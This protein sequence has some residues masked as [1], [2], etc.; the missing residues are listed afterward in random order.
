MKTQLL[1]FLSIVI[2]SNALIIQDDE[3]NSILTELTTLAEKDVHHENEDPEKDIRTNILIPVDDYN[4]E[5]KSEM[6]EVTMVDKRV[7]RTEEPTDICY[8][9]D[10][11]EHCFDRARNGSACE[12]EELDK[13]VVCCNVTD[14]AKSIGCLGSTN[15]KN[16]HI[17]NA[18]EAEVNLNS[19]NSHLKQLDSLAITNG[20]I[21]RITGAFSKF[22]SIKCL[23]FASNKIVEVYD[24]ALLHANQLKFL[25]LSENNITRLPSIQNVTVNVQ[26]NSKISCINISTALDKEVKFLHKENSYCER[27]TVYWWFNDTAS[28]TIL[29]LEKMKKLNEECPLGCRC[30]P[31]TMQYVSNTLEVTAKVD[32]SSLGL[33][34]FPLKL[35][36]ETV[37]LIVSNNSISS[38]STL[39]SSEYYQ[40]V[41][42]LFIDDNEISSMEELAGTKFFENFTILSLKNNKI[43]EIPNYILSSLEKNL[44]SG[45]VSFNLSF[46]IFN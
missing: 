12:C 26:G 25:N 10:I 3:Q 15:L 18:M 1:V 9:V 17:I 16:L 21:T 36:S 30:I 35:P 23:N 28:V 32:C 29:A 31:S 45:K 39:V 24:R 11:R 13:G 4:E 33:F 43:K 46:F 2:F 37:E 40:N 14:I 27:E 6:M 41:Q 7:E 5:E 22:T 19:L 38:L 20:N 42:R 8:H 44:N 34:K